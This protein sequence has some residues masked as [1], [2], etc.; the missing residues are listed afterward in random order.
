[1]LQDLNNLKEDFFSKISEISTI[2]ELED[3]RV[4]FLGKKGSFTALMQNL[5]NLNNEEKRLAGSE[6]NKTK[7]EIVGIVQQKKEEFELINLNK[8]QDKQLEKMLFV[9]FQ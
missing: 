5:R 8:K 1:M 9:D 6:L 3:I 2:E 4:S 7:I